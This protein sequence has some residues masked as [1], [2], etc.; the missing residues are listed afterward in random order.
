V[1]RLGHAIEFDQDLGFL[2]AHEPVGEK[3]ALKMLH[4]ALANPLG[5]ENALGEDLKRRKVH[6]L[7]P[8]RLNGCRCLLLLCVNLR[9]GPPCK[10]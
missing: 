5:G 3:L 9:V 1:D 10:W 2:A 4:V 8:P 7:T 6:L